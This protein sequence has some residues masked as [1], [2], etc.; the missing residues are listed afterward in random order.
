MLWRFFCKYEI[1]NCLYADRTES[2]EKLKSNYVGYGATVGT[3]HLSMLELMQ[4]V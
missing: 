4:L 2:L 3:T 1:K